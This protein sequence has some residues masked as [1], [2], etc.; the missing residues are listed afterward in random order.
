MSENVEASISRNPKG[1]H[2]LYRDNFAL[3]YWFLFVISNN[4]ECSELVTRQEAR[5][6]HS[7]LGLGA[8]KKIGGQPVK[9]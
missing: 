5:K 1:L 4:S 6:Q 9:N 3:F 8:H 2:G 7:E